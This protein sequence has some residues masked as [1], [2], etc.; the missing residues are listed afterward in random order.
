MNLTRVSI[1]KEHWTRF[2]FGIFCFIF[3]NLSDLVHDKK[4]NQER[5]YI[6]IIILLSI[7]AELIKAYNFLAVRLFYM[8]GQNIW[9][10]KWTVPTPNTTHKNNIIIIKI[11]LSFN[12]VILSQINIHNYILTKWCDKKKLCH[13]RFHSHI[14]GLELSKIIFSINHT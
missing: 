8:A 10:S 3:R 4:P 13:F 14:I 12:N 9:I 6:Y 7:L 11:M 2:I 1:Q 5:I